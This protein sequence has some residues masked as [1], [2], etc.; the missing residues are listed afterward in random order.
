MG[1]RVVWYVETSDSEEVVTSLFYT[2]D[3]GSGLLRNFGKYVPGCPASHPRRQQFERSILIF[4]NSVN[5]GEVSGG[6]S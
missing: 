2:G 4:V 5:S 3:G 6:T 1:H